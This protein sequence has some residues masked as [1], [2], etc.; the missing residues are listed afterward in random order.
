[1]QEALGKNV[2]KQPS[3]VAGITGNVDG[4]QRQWMAPQQQQQRRSLPSKHHSAN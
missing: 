1:M 2:G 4:F 3:L